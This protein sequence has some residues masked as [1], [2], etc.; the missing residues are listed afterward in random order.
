[1]DTPFQQVALYGSVG[2]YALAGIFCAARKTRPGIGV[3]AAGLLFHALYLIGR[4]WLGGIFIPNPLLEGP[5]FLPWCLALLALLGGLRGEDPW[6]WLLVLLLLFCVF[7]LAYPRGIAPPSPKKVTPWALAFF[8]SEVLA[9]ACFY[10]GALYGVLALL[11]K[12]VQGGGHTY[13]IWGFILYSVAQIVGALWNFHGWGNTFSWSSRHMRSAG[14]WLMY[15]AYL[16]LS[17]VSRS[18]PRKRA[19]YALAAAMVVLWMTTSHYIDE[20]THTRIGG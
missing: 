17:Y 9:H 20:M 1:M 15:A 19:W 3:L 4:G 13:I 2:L 14:T 16:H 8:A 11:G 7:E 5:Y 12:P 6:V 10:A 18:S